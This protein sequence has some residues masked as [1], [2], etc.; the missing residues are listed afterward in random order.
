M[1]FLWQ[2]VNL[3]LWLR[4]LDDLRMMRGGRRQARMTSSRLPGKVLRAARR[5]SPRCSSCSS[6]LEHCERPDA[7]VVATST[8]RATT[9]SRSSASG[10][11]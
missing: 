3:E 9:R 6:A 11:A 7:V 2:L 8:T 4:W 10:S 1:M 5:R